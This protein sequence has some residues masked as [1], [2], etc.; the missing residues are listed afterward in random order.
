MQYSNPQA[1]VDAVCRYVLLVYK[2]PTAV[3]EDHILRFDLYKKMCITGGTAFSCYRSPIPRPPQERAIRS[4]S[5]VL[6]YAAAL[7]SGLGCT[8]PEEG[9]SYC[10]CLYSL[11]HTEVESIL[12]CFLAALSKSTASLQYRGQHT[13]RV[14]CVGIGRENGVIRHASTDASE[15]TRA[16]C[17]HNIL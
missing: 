6:V 14:V 5:R 11:V 9:R 16:K 8:D 4:R 15:S 12:H 3:K 7:R 2:C 17:V 1:I 10:C 13:I